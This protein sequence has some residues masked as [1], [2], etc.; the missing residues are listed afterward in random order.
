MSLSSLVEPRE[1]SQQEKVGNPGRRTFIKTLGA[2]G[3]AAAASAAASVARGPFVWAQGQTYNW[4]MATT[5]PR[6]LA[7]FHDGAERFARIVEERSGGRLRIKVYAAGELVPAFETFN[8]VSQGKAEAGHSVSFYW[9]EK[10]PAAPWFSAVPF[11]FN[12]QGINA[13]MYAGGGIKLW[14]EVYAPFNVVPR[15]VGN[16]GVQMGGW[17]KRRVDSPKDLKGLKMR[18]GGLGALVLKKAGAQVMYIPGGEVLAALESGKV[19]AADWVGPVHDLQ[20]GLYKAAKYYYYPGWH[21]PGSTIEVLFNKKAYDAL[22]RDLRE[23]LDGVAME[24]NLWTLCQFE[25]QN[26]R[27]LETLVSQLNVQLVRFPVPVLNELRTLSAQVLAEEAA[28]DPMVKKVNDAFRNFEKDL[29]N[30]SYISER[31]YYD[32]LAAKPE[33]LEPWV[34]KDVYEY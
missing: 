6:G 10:I 19:D 4:R 15:P 14:E 25:S 23:I 17:F 11:G 3:A 32:F 7:I 21:E 28:K 5:W 2:V 8:A 34:Y 27:A 33:T 26:F 22:P 9:E 12:A 24:N 13:W 1:Q 16:T 30:W 31:A 20:M 29:D 18:I